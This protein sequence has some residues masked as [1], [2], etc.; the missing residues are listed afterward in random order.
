MVLKGDIF[1]KIF[2]LYLL[3]LEYQFHKLNYYNIYL[4]F[5]FIELW[6]FGN[7]LITIFL[8]I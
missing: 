5:D 8:L 7:L 1:I 6:I 2:F 4:S 3:Y